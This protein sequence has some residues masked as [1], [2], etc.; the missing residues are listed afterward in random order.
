MP[1]A[2]GWTYP[3]SVTLLGVR[4]TLTRSYLLYVLLKLMLQYHGL[5][6]LRL[7]LLRPLSPGPT[8]HLPADESK[9]TGAVVSELTI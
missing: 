1:K 8:H 3:L 5:H 2:D 6:D 7:P 9:D 4:K